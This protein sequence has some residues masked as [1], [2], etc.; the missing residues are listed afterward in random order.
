MP[1]AEG[2]EQA[3]TVNEERFNR[4]FLMMFVT[5]GDGYFYSHGS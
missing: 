1:V 2:D 5:F 4:S 3:A